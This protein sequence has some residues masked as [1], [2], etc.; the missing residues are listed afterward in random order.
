MQV[1]RETEEIPKGKRSV[2]LG[3]GRGEICEILVKERAGEKTQEHK[4]EEETRAEEKKPPQQPTQPEP[5]TQHNNTNRCYTSDIYKHHHSTT[6]RAS[7]HQTKTKFP[8]HD[9][10]RAKHPTTLRCLTSPTSTAARPCVA[11]A[12]IPTAT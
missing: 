1:S 4:K 11:A 3:A 10:G 7:C 6:R 12:A 8:R 5:P 9:A 2:V